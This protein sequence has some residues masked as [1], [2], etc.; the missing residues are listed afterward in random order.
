MGC[1]SSNDASRGA[2]KEKFVRTKANLKDLRATY[3]I[4]KNLLGKGS[5]GMVYKA[6]NKQNKDQQI[7][8]KAIDKRKLTKEEINDIHEEVKTIQAVDHANIV[9]YFETYEDERFVYLCMELCTGGELIEESSKRKTMDEKH[10]ADVMLQLLSALNH[11]HASKIIHRDIKPE[12]IMYD[13]PNGTV[14]FIDFGLACQMS[15]GEKDLAGTP[16]FIA[17]EVLTNYYDKQCDIWSLGVV[18]YQLMSGNLPFTGTSQETLFRAIKL[19]S[20]PIPKHF[21][22]DL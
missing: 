19:K 15:K 3:D 11:I 9:N 14:K 13:H 21:S 1:V 18:L 5:F 8:I 20:F 4:D 17:P 7:A 12:N 16:Y 6:A 10:G 22:P 2:S